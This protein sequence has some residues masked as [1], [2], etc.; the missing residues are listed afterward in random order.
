MPFDTKNIIRK[1]AFKTKSRRKLF[2]W[3]AFE[4]SS[5][6][7]SSLEP[8]SLEPPSLEPPS[9]EP[10]SLKPSSLEPSSWRFSSF[11]ELASSVNQNSKGKTTS[12]IP[13]R[14]VKIYRTILYWIAIYDC[15]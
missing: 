7:P 14:A 5:L 9:L 8:P 12:E 1:G 3:D 2:F 15:S 13:N 4:P 6:E 10:P 11:W